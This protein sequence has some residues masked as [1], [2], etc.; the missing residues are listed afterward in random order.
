LDSHKDGVVSATSPTTGTVPPEISYG[1]AQPVHIGSVTN[2]E[3]AANG[4]VM[5]I[6]G[7]SVIHR[8]Y[9]K[10]LGMHCCF[11]LWSCFDK[12]LICSL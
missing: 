6:D 8:A 2:A 9:Y 3:A 5:L 4:R 11:L 10:L 1:A 12:Q 7:T